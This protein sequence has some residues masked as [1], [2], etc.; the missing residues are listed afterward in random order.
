[1][2]KRKAKSPRRPGKQADELLSAAGRFLDRTVEYASAVAAELRRCASPPIQPDRQLLQVNCQALEW[3]LRTVGVSTDGKALTDGKVLNLDALEGYD[4]S[5]VALLSCFATSHR[6]RGRP[7]MKSLADLAEETRNTVI[8][9]GSRPTKELVDGWDRATSDL[10]DVARNLKAGAER[11]RQ[12]PKGAGP[13]QEIVKIC[14]EMLRLGREPGSGE[15]FIV[16][17]HHP[18]K[19]PKRKGKAPP[20]AEAVPAVGSFRHRSGPS[21]LLGRMA[22]VLDDVWEALSTE[23]DSRAERLA[24][25]V[26][27]LD[28][29]YDT[30]TFYSPAPVSVWE[31]YPKA[32][33]GD[34]SERDRWWYRK[35]WDGEI[36]ADAFFAQLDALQE[37]RTLQE[38]TKMQ[39][40][41]RVFDIPGHRIFKSDPAL[42]RVFDERFNTLREWAAERARQEKTG[43]KKNTGDGEGH[44]AAPEPTA[45]DRAAAL[46]VKVFQDRPDAEKREYLKAAAVL[47]A[48]K[49][50]HPGYDRKLGT[51]ARALTALVK[52]GTLESKTNA[53]YRLPPK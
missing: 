14:D 18:S 15:G 3:Q 48:V 35:N 29:T 28:L 36:T 23:F 20:D 46:I 9:N 5:A 4:V 42:V 13:A 43:G 38:W 39:W 21:G 47:V 26:K 51:I 40:P 45:V 24:V 49:E 1:M 44:G 10:A 27:A 2:S 7:A 12:E 19:R 16:T 22:M 31:V 32:R 11:A 25:L 34:L 8:K 6:S 50:K 33:K 53:G 30:T 17:P 52:T 41:G 37:S